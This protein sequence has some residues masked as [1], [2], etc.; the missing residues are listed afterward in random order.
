M[1][2]GD[3][4]LGEIG[5]AIREVGR[6]VVLRKETSGAYDETTGAAALASKDYPD[7]DAVIVAYA[8]ILVNN[9]TVLRQDR[10]C[11]LA[12]AGL[13]DGI[14]PAVGDRVIAA[15]DPAY[16]IIDPGRVELSG[17]SL[18]YKMQVRSGK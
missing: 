3:D 1:S 7:L 13:P 17:T 6:K 10:K 8:D 11:Y 16:T 12:A 14:S 9:T 2:I 4:L 15:P 18:L 5:V